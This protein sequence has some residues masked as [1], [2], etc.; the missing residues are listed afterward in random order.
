MVLAYRLW[1]VTVAVAF[2]FSEIVASGF[3]S[4]VVKNVTRFD[5]V[6]DKLFITDSVI[7]QIN[8]RSGE[9]FTNVNLS[10]H[11]SNPITQLDAWIED[12][13]GY[14][15][16]RLKSKDIIDV[17]AV[18][19]SFYADDF[20]KKFS[21][22]HNE[23]PY[24][25]CYTY[26]QTFRQF[27][28]V[29]DWCPVF[30]LDMPTRAAKLIFTHPET[31]Q[32]NINQ[33]NIGQPTIYSHDGIVVMTWNA[34]YNGDI[35]EE[36]FCPSTDYFLPQVCIE[37][38]HFIYNVPGKNISWQSFGEWQN[39]LI[40]GLDILPESEKQAVLF[41]I[42]NINDKKEI[43]RLLYH[44]LQDNTRYIDVYIGTGGLKPYPAS[45]VSQHHYGDCKALSIYMKALLKNAG[46]DSYY[47]LVYASSQPRDI[48]E[49]FPSQQFNHVI[50]AVPLEGDTIW[51][52]NT[53]NCNPFAYT[54]TFLQNREALLID[55]FSKLIKIPPL[56]AYEVMEVQKMVFE[57]DY[58]GSANVQSNAVLSGRRF[59]TFNYLL[60][61][62]SKE[63]QNKYILEFLPF[64]DF[65]LEEWNIIKY[66]RDQRSL[67]LEAK[68][69][70]NQFARKL[71]DEFYFSFQP[72]LIPE[73]EPASIRRLPVQLPYP[74]FLTDTLIYHLPKGAIIQSKPLS[75]SLNSNYG[76][77]QLQVFE[78]GET[79][80]ILRNV[81]LYPGSIPVE[82]YVH[83]FDFLSR[84]KIADKQKILFK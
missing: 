73:F 65:D 71:S 62:A 53:S 25:I 50:L 19:S 67:E 64:A 58:N 33:K 79:I 80:T 70:L 9:V 12:H 66:G 5:I 44:Y 43:V 74:I 75:Q 22:K 11:K 30:R 69:S 38:I 59:E 23:Y 35:Q 77:Y 14:I 60:T 2:S 84:I 39:K 68:L 45:Y 40:E 6:N 36:V 32:V 55:S 29:G 13:N 47:T 18:S 78:S 52:E 57:V 61:N 46:I 7:I 42:L 26:N 4:E 28:S 54:S 8:N 31:F 41:Q 1:F 56:Q 37:P 48:F 51:L 20:T 76:E 16:R 82:E 72:A 3:N 15:V 63:E 24:R 27:F 83:F 17:N 10:Y 34:S 21:L 81:L 49:D